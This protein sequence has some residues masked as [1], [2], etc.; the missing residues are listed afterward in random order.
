MEVF[1]HVIEIGVTPHADDGERGR[2]RIDHRRA[3]LTIMATPTASTTSSLVA[4]AC[5]HGGGVGI[6]APIAAQRDR[7]PSAIT[8]RVFASMRVDYALA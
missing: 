3:V 4:P 7:K 2:R 8:S 6:D 5:D 1:Q